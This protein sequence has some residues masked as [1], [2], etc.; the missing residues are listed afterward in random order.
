M[1][2]SLENILLY[3]VML[4]VLA[5]ALWDY[6]KSFEIP[7]V[8][9]LLPFVIGLASLVANHEYLIL[10]LAVLLVALTEIPLVILRR[11]A[12]LICILII[13]IIR[14]DMG[15]FIFLFW[16]LYEFNLIAGADAL[17]CLSFLLVR[18]DWLLGWWLIMGIGLGAWWIGLRNRGLTY[19]KDMINSW[20]NI[21]NSPPSEE[22][23]LKEGRPFLWAIFLGSVLYVFSSFLLSAH[24]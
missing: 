1:P 6:F 22:R 2:I 14:W 10:A 18:P 13:T 3:L 7:P 20:R 21:H 24:P 12:V 9:V 23:L 16:F 4:A 5:S 15:L 8:L 19:F 17:A 11:I